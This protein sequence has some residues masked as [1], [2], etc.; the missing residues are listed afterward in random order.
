MITDRTAPCRICGQA[1]IDAQ[2]ILNVVCSE[3]CR[4][5]AE[6]VGFFAQDIKEHA[7]NDDPRIFF[8][9]IGFGEL[10]DKL[11]IFI[12]R[13]VW[14]KNLDDQLTTDYLIERIM[15]SVITKVNKS[16][17]HPK[18]RENIANIFKSLY[19]VNA[20]MWRLRQLTQ[21]ESIQNELR[22]ASSMAYFAHS[23]RRDQHR[24][25]LDA[26]VEGR[27]RTVRVY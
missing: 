7:P 22:S 4:L 5:G 6:K 23:L 27:V 14:Q 3:R 25:Q 8:Y 19:A 21:N 15:Q 10:C 12:L 11:C 1:V 20:E 16:C 13:R 26:I 17:H 9:D 24:A 18:T 2:D